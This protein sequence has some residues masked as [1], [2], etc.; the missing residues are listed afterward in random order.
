MGSEPIEQW[1]RPVVPV[2]WVHEVPASTRS[3]QVVFPE[4]VTAEAKALLENQVA[5]SIAASTVGLLNT[6]VTISFKTD[7]RDLNSHRLQLQEAICVAAAL[8]LQTDQPT[9]WALC[10]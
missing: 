2:I 3:T 10:C 7:L 4:H 1:H 8:I 9:F 6:A 5:V